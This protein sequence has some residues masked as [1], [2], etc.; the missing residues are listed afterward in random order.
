MP[1]MTIYVPAELESQLGVL[2]PRSIS[3]ICQ[4][5]LRKAV[6]AQAAAPPGGDGDP[7]ITKAQAQRI[8]IE[9]LPPDLPPGGHVIKTIEYQAGDQP[10]LRF[11]Y[12]GKIDRQYGPPVA[13][14]PL[15]PS[16]VAGV[17]VARLAEALS[18]LARLA[19]ALDWS[20]SPAEIERWLRE[21]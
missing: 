4:D 17:N 15:P 16:P 10:V 2:P 3:R 21:S 1:D 12:A 18:T 13:G 5:A 9:G 19:G 14:V 20:R 8:E 6:A 11:R 7:L